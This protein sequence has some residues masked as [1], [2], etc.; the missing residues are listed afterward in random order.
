MK[1]S[2]E[3]IRNVANEVFS[4]VPSY[5]LMGDIDGHPTYDSIEKLIK[6]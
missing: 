1:I 5:A 4:S 3:D 2:R 6:V